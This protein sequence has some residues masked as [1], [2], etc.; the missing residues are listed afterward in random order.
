MGIAF[1]LNEQIRLARGKYF[2]RMDA[3]DLM[4][5]ERIKE[6][7]KYLEDNRAVDVLGSSA[8]IIDDKH[9]II[10]F[11]QSLVHSSMEQVFS[12]VPFI[13][14]TVT[15]KTE[16]FRRYGYNNDLIGAE[17]FYLWIMSFQQSSF[18]TIDR[19][20]LYYRDPPEIKV[21]TYLFR[22]RQLRHAIWANRG[23]IKEKP[24]F[25]FSLIILTYCKGIFM[26]LAER[27]HFDNH[28]IKYR[29]E[30][31]DTS[32]LEEYQIT[33]DSILNL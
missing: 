32:I 5:T 21:Q 20:L 33:L 25:L 4:H 23:V 12:K 11:R 13:H 3:D 22:Q 26:V 8:L 9:M 19:P 28:L 24:F 18:S 6:Q 14:P 16:W 17:D 29:N 31:P 1:R 30:S 15:G 7:I 10:G 27:R 2:A